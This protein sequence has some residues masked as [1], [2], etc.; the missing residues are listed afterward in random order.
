MK[1][2]YN[3]ILKAVSAAITNNFFPKHQGYYITFNSIDLRTMIGNCVIECR[4]STLNSYFVCDVRKDIAILREGKGFLIRH[5]NEHP[6][7]KGGLFETHTTIVTE[8]NIYE[9]LAKNMIDSIDSLIR[10][11]ELK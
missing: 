11:H 10:L 6:L 2:D 3:E 9:V 7:R 4:V 1:L 5:L 8:S